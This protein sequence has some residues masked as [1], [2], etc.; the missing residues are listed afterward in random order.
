MDLRSIRAFLAACAAACMPAI[1]PAQVP[2]SSIVIV[3]EFVNTFTGHYFM[4]AS[5]DEAAGIANGAAGPG[6]QS[7]TYMFVA[8]STTG[9]PVCRFYAPPP[10]NS[11]FYT[12]DAAECDSLKTHD[13]GWKYEG[14]AF[15]IDVPSNGAC[16]SG[17]S[18]VTH[19]YNNGAAALD[20]NHRFNGDDR[21]VAQMQAQGWI[22]EG[23]AFC[24]PNVFR[25]FRTLNNFLASS[26]PP[27]AYCP[28]GSASG[29][30]P[31]F[32][33]QLSALLD[34]TETV[35]S[36][37]PP[38]LGAHNPAYTPDFAAKTGWGSNVDVVF[39]RSL[40]DTPA[41]RS[42]VEAF[43]GGVLV[44]VHVVGSERRF[45]DY[46]AISPS[47][48]GIQDPTVFGGG[49]L[50]P[51]GDRGAHDVVVNFQLKVTT[52]IRASD[53]AQVSG[54]P[55]LDFVDVTSGQRVLVRVLAYGSQAPADVAGVD[56]VSGLPMVSTSFAA[57]SFGRALKGQ[58]IACGFATSATGGCAAS[59]IDYSFR[60]DQ[61]DFARVLAAARPFSAALSGDIANYRLAG[62]QM[63]NQ[64]FGDAELGLVENAI[65]VI[66]TK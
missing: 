22:V 54:G 11:H 18:P 6:W 66:V 2:G 58:Y 45:G 46:A 15:R 64:T 14:I 50:L 34:M 56:P 36:W 40:A 4:T 23:V 51:W 53:S 41:E 7:T 61:S 8:S 62:M 12:A 52:V 3:Q 42:F 20:S 17:L 21:I 25:D 16:A 31:E 27:S 30:N 59:G 60:I 43:G 32:C 5:Q 19:M 26:A 24:S 28:T 55:M 37:I 9:A 39:S 10:T 48:Y 1:A 38:D 65:Q 44:G 47:M 57:P 63:R 35:R 49:A 33:V 29:G 13:T